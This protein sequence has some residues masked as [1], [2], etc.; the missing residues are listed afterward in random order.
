MHLKQIEHLETM[1]VS[2]ETD[3]VEVHFASTMCTNE[4]Y[5]DHGLL[6]VFS[7]RNFWVHVGQSVGCC[8][9]SLFLQL[10]FLVQGHQNMTVYKRQFVSFFVHVVSMSFL[11]FS[12]FSPRLI[13]N[14]LVKFTMLDSFNANWQH[15][16]LDL[17]SP[18]TQFLLWFCLSGNSEM[19]VYPVK[20][21]K[22][23]LLINSL[24]IY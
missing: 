18:L 11:S 14:D 2:R 16:R 19:H 12:W 7:S 21:I 17:D 13:Q 24:F 20:M 4:P 15:R 3:S 10:T 23:T 5:F 9:H 8:L 1:W 22:V 6:S